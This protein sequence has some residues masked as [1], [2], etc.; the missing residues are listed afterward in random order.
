MTTMSVCFY[1]K[2]GTYTRFQRDERGYISIITRDTKEFN[3]VVIPGSLSIFNNMIDAFEK[4][5]MYV[6]K[7]VTYTYDK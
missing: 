2:D 4:E 3:H 1:T 5:G 7:E 6:T